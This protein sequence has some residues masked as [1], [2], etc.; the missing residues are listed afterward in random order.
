MC[1][2]VQESNCLADN[3]ASIHLLPLLAEPEASPDEVVGVVVIWGS[4]HSRCQ[5]D[6]SVG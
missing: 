4:S 6:V 3:T 2:N 5:N 1:L